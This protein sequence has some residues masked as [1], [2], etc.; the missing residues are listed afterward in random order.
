MIAD[1]SHEFP[2]CGN[3]Q[4]QGH[5][6]SHAFRHQQQRIRDAQQRVDP[7]GSLM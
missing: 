2:T 5:L 1:I 3:S 7:E 4:M 6:L